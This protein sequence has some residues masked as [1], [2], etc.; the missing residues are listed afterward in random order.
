VESVSFFLEQF[1][2]YGVLKNVQL[3]GPPCIFGSLA[4]I[5]AIPV[6]ALTGV[7]LDGATLR[8]LLPNLPHFRHRDTTPAP[9]VSQSRLRR[10]PRLCTSDMIQQLGEGC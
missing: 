2:I 9:A 8:N 3:F 4:H 1:Q 10:A 6:I 7:M 5:D